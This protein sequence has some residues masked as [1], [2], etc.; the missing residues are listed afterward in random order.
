MLC[1]KPDQAKNTPT[2]CVVYQGLDDAQS[3]KRVFG[4]T[5]SY[6]PQGNLAL[7]VRGPAG[8]A[9]QKGLV[10]GVD[11]GQTYRAPFQTC[12]QNICQAGEAN[13]TCCSCHERKTAP[14]RVAD[15]RF[16]RRAG[17]A[18]EAASA[19]TATTAEE[20]EAAFSGSAGDS[21]KAA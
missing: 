11:G 9:L 12:A 17:C 1:G 5:V 14:G 16:C 21:A 20:V 15:E 8:V 2:S 13:H 19:R 18:R 4:Q 10:I 7:M 6:G 3:K